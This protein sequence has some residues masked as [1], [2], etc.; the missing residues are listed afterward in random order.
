MSDV[1]KVAILEAAAELFATQGFDATSVRD[2]AAAADSQAGSVFYHFGSKRGL[3][4]EVVREGSVRA[5]ARVEEQLDGV[6]DPRERLARALRGHLEAL[7]G[8]ESRPFTVVGNEW[9]TK[10]T[11]EELEVVVPARDAYE[12]LWREVLADAAQAGVVT[13]DPLLRLL[14]LGATNFTVLW[15][16]PDAGLSLDE[17]CDR[18]LA[19]VTYP[20]PSEA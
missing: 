7:Q 15:Y 2:V 9:L 8:P 3:L 10:L 16:R 11:P 12:Q 13:D 20:E 14:V 19:F 5:R 1:R 18:F 17:L 6:D 4:A